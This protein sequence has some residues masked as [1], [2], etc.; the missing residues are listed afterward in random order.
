MVLAVLGGA[1][2]LAATTDRAETLYY[3]CD[4][5]GS[6]KLVIPW[7]G[8]PTFYEVIDG[9]LELQPSEITPKTVRFW[10][11][12]KD[13]LDNPA[14]NGGGMVIDRQTLLTGINQCVLSETPATY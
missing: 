1:G 5:L 10:L 11:N 12:D 6:Y 2:Y 14:E 3:G 7:F 13:R 9:Q 8:E 4:V